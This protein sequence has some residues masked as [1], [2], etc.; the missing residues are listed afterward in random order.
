M[1][2]TYYTETAIIGAGIVGLS[3]ALALAKVGQAVML[4]DPAAPGS[5]ASYGNASSISP[6]AI[7]PVGSPAVL[8][9]LPS[10]LFDRESPLSIRPAYLALL[11]PWLLRFAV[12]SLPTTTMRNLHIMAELQ[13]GS[14]AAW[15][16]LAD[17]VDI[18]DLLVERGV[19]YTYPDETSLNAAQGTVALRRGYGIPQEVLSARQVAELEPNLPACAGAVHHVGSIHLS[20]TGEATRRMAEAAARLGVLLLDAKVKGIVCE[21]S[22]PVL[23]AGENRILAKRVVIAAGAHSADLARQ[24][25][26][27]VPLIAHRGYHVEFDMEE[28]PVSRPVHRTQLG[29]YMT[30]LRGRLRAAGTV[31]LASNEA[32]PSTRRFDQIERGV[33][34]TFPNMPPVARRWMGLRPAMPDSLPVIGTSSGGADVIYAFGHGHVGL[35]LGP[36]TAQLVAALATGRP[37]P[38]LIRHFSPN[39]FARWGKR[40]SWDV[41]K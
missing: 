16:E 24:L 12:Q 17:N 21:A 26:D 10:L 41:L 20:D 2:T 14:M 31:E 9:S 37:V 33:R 13:R 39:R 5:G 30:P 8:R 7:S 25:G 11:A 15:R 27:R 4:I 36:V 23:H 18:A 22:G 6:H 32:A 1:P 29:Y 40:N 38:E 19:L 3:C 28:T 34:A 35:T